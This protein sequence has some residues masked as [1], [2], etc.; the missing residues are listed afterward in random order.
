MANNKN[1]KGSYKFLAKTQKPDEPTIHVQMPSGA[2]RIQDIVQQLELFGADLTVQE[3]RI[4]RAELEGRLRNGEEFLLPETEEIVSLVDEPAMPQPGLIESRA[5][6]STPPMSQDATEVLVFI[7][8]F[9][10]CCLGERR[11]LI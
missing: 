1:R 3:R 5:L 8:A 6:P 7:S 10:F 4:L 9:L 11:R 2:I